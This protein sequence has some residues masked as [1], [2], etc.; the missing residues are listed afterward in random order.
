MRKLRVNRVYAA[1]LT[2]IFAA[3]SMLQAKAESTIQGAASN[4]PLPLGGAGVPYL[5]GTAVIPGSDELVYIE[6]HSILPSGLTQVAYLGPQ[7]E[8]IAL[9]TLD[10]SQREFLPDVDVY[11]QRLDRRVRVVHG[12]ECEV[13][14]EQP[15]GKLDT[16]VL[17]DHEVSDAGFDKFIVSHFDALVSGQ[18]KSFRFLLPLRPI[19]VRLGVRAQDCKPRKDD[20]VCFKIAPTNWLFKAFTDP[21]H[22]Q[23]QLSSKRLLSFTGLGQLADEKGEPIEVTLSYEYL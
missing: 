1:V 13:S 7:R 20:T 18:K 23:Y 4:E 21:I 5:I 12:E 16:S 2:A 10:F 9:K 8:P 15:K 3:S 19:E 6:E 14:I 11:D 22:V 17:G